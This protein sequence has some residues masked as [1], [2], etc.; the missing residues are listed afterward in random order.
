MGLRSSLLALPLLAAAGS[1]RAHGGLSADAGLWGGI[2]H[3]L[4]GPDHL[5]AALAVGLLAGCSAARR[6]L[7]ALFLVGTLAGMLLAGLIPAVAPLEWG[8][9]ASVVVL[10]GLLLMPPWRGHL[11]LAAL[12][13]TAALLHGHAHGHE[14]GAAAGGWL[15]VLLAQAA[16]LALGRALGSLGRLPR[17]AAAAIGAFGGYLALT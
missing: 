1:A 11:A 8:L 2:Q 16:V 12:V 9:A 6:G 13:L 15:G 7:P 10:A 17:I 4:S 3:V 14:L 5:L